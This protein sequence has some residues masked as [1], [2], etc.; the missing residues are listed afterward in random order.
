MTLVKLCLVRSSI[1]LK[2]VY[3]QIVITLMMRCFS[4]NVIR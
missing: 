2:T 3:C 4:I 1:N